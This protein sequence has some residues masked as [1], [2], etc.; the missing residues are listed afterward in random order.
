MITRALVIW[1]VLL[2]LAVANGGVREA[3]L[4]PRL[5]EGKGRALSTI[6]LSLAI[7]LLTWL[8][9][10]WMHPSSLG[11]AWTIGG[12]WLALTLAFEFLAGHFVFRKPWSEL[13]ADY[14]VLAGRIWILVLIVTALA[15][16]LVATVQGLQRVPD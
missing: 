11:D 3:L 5:G 10:R 13:L 7:L 1:I 16:Y 8:S 12:L 4:I 14:N 2:V 15:P 9:L 6:T